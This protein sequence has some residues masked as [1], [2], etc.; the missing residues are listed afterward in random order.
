MRDNSRSAVV[1][2]STA[3]TF[4]ADVMRGL[5]A[6]QKN[7]PCKYL[8]DH[9]GSKLFEEICQLD[10]YY[11]TRVELKIMRQHV[12]EMAQQI[13][14]RCLLIEYGSGSGVKTEKLLHYLEDP[15]GYIPVDI[16][17]KHLRRSVVRLRRQFSSLTIRPVFGDF[18]KRLKFPRLKSPAARKVVYFPGSTIGNF[19]TSEAV[20]LLRGISRRCGPG[21]GLLIG[22]DLKK[23]V[24]VLEAAYNDQKGITGKFNLNLLHRIN[25]ELDADFELAKF[26]HN[27]RYNESAGCIEIHLVS[28]QDQ[29]VTVAGRRIRFSAGEMVHTENSHKYTV[30]EFDDLAVQ[31]GLKKK[32]TW[33]DDQEMFSIHYFVTV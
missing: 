14:P 2:Q 33:V 25:R 20:S 4:R 9:R 1:G 29:V 21:G 19:T 27:A 5:C 24:A 11:L 7:L 6:Q 30:Q 10:E 16:S 18:T 31:G 22:V 12:S 23:D 32:Q 17:R 15:A 28:L 8:Y 3:E 13:G 26:R